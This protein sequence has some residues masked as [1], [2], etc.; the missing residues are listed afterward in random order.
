MKIID[1]SL[2]IDDEAFEVHKVSIERVSHKEGIE[3][4]NSVMGKPILKKATSRTMNSSPLRPYMHPC[5]WGHIWI[6]LF[7]TAPAVRAAPQKPR[8]KYP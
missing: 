3:K 8:R 7:I 2:P 4:F 5:M 6:T 1:L